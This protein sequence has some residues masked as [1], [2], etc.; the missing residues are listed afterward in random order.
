M[1]YNLETMHRSGNENSR[2][3]VVRLHREEK[4][5]RENLVISEIYSIKPIDALNAE[6]RY[7]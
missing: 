6:I 3:H 1:S 5:R 4:L 7:F 2:E